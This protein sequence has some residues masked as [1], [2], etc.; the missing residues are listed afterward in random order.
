MPLPQIT[1]PPSLPPFLIAGHAAEWGSPFADIPMGT[2]HGRKRRVVTA[3]PQ[4][5]SVSLILER[6]QMTAFHLWFR[7]TLRSGQRRFSANVKEQGAGMLWYDAMWLQM[8]QWTAMHLGRWR[9][10][11]VLQ[12]RGD[13]STVG[14]TL[15]L[16]SGG[17]RIAFTGTAR[18]SAANLFQGGARIALLKALRFEG[19]ASIALEGV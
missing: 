14:P 5:I 8:P 17:A 18:V 16:F 3:R 11:G 9:V 13:S 4:I 7:D 12:A 2:G 10:D 6:A 15:G 1:L 19:G